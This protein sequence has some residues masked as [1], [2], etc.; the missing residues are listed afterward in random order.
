[1]CVLLF[2][3]IQ[4]VKCY[5]ALVNTLRG[6]AACQ[7][8]K[9]CLCDDVLLLF[10][11]RRSVNSVRHPLSAHTPL[12]CYGVAKL[13]VR[14]TSKTYGLAVYLRRNFYC[15]AVEMVVAPNVVRS[16]QTAVS[17]V[18]HTA[19]EI[20]VLGGNPFRVSCDGGFR[21]ANTFGVEGRGC[22]LGVCAG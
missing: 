18:F 22:V 2:A 4:L 16:L 12:F 20:A 10:T 11:L 3:V 13:L 15:F 6:V 7:T 14:V 1:M 9:E 21:V 8:L 5:K 19:E 17:A